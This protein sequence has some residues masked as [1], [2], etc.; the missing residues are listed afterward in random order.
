MVDVCMG[1]LQIL[2]D[3]VPALQSETNTKILKAITPI[4]ISAQRDVRLSICDLLDALAE[5]DSSIRSMV[6]LLP[7]LSYLTTIT[8]Y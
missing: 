1:A 8:E 5:K 3:I 7:K 4:L 6:K 2:R